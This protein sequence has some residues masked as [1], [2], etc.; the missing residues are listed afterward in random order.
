[1][2]NNQKGENTQ[3]WALLTSTQL[4][5]AI[6][7]NSKKNT[8][9]VCT[10][11][12]AA[13]IKA[14]VHVKITLPPSLRVYFKDRQRCQGNKQADREHAGKSLAL[15]FGSTLASHQASL[16]PSLQALVT[17][18]PSRR[19]RKPAWQTCASA[20]HQ[21]LVQCHIDP[22]HLDR[23]LTAFCL[24]MCWIVLTLNR[25]HANERQTWGSHRRWKGSNGA[26]LDMVDEGG[27]SPRSVLI[28]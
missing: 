2:S 15:N 18:L 20:G 1:M 21:F 14:W 7:L 4:Q 5:N 6:N 8:W 23:Y 25:S 3:L 12:H 17:S 26:N 22:P 16:G 9:D 28:L 11:T 24:Q 27:V 10:C 13:D 19:V